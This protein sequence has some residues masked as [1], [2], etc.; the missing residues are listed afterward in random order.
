MPYEMNPKQY[1]TVFSLSAKERYL[2][3]IGKVADWEQ[4]WGLYNENDGWLTR[5]TPD[6]IEYI[7][8]WPHPEYANEIS[9]EHYPKYKEKEISYYPKW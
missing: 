2:H 9:K 3:F 6:G 1:E 5:T 8:V 7:S 4:L